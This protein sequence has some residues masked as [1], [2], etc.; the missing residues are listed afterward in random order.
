[1]KESEKM[2]NGCKVTIL[3]GGGFIGG[4][5]ARYLAER[6]YRVS[7][8]DLQEPA[9]KA[10]GVTYLTGDFFRDESLEKITEDAEVVI[11]ALSTINPG[12]SN[13]DFLRGYA[14]DF[15]QTVKLFDLACKKGIRVIFLSSAGTVYGRYDGEPFKERHALQPINHYGSVKACVETA[16]RSFNEQQGGRHL[17]CRITNPYGPGQDYRKGVGFIDAVIR[18]CA[19]GSKLEIWGDGSVVRDYIYIDDVCAMLERLI[20]YDG[21]WHVF[22]LSTGIG[23]SQMEILEIFRELGCSPEAEFLPARAVDARTNLAA[24]DRIREITG[25]ECVPLKDGIRSYLGHLGIL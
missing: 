22:N 13:R 9:E 2:K 1:M 6:G 10:E 4:N 23:H 8:F 18:N 14:G 20:R 12:T 5:L 25:I 3:G 7:V 17:S 24:N 11:H 16:M 15:V 21:E 19:E